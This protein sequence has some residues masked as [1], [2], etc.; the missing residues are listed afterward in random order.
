MRGTKLKSVN[1]YLP[2]YG[3]IL[4]ELNS[5][6]IVTGCVSSTYGRNYFNDESETENG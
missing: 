1:I 3:A 5:W 6:I 4:S 2:K